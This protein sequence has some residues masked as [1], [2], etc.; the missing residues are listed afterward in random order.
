MAGNQRQ[1][2]Q[3]AQ[4]RPAR[5]DGQH[6]SAGLSGGKV[7]RQRSGDRVRVAEL[8][9]GRPGRASGEQT[10]ATV[11]VD[12]LQQAVMQFRQDRLAGAGRSG[13]LVG[14]RVQPVAKDL[15]GGVQP[16]GAQVVAGR[17]HRSGSRRA[18]TA[19]ANSRQAARSLPSVARPAAVSS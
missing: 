16:W 6:G 1:Q 4:Q 13:E 19:V 12:C 18:L 3:A 17:G 10:A 5:E 11:A 8:D 14:E 2:P 7:H 15:V 9:H